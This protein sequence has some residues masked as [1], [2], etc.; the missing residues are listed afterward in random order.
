MF[1]HC[2]FCLKAIRGIKLWRS[3]KNLQVYVMVWMTCLNPYFLDCPTLIIKTL[4]PTCASLLTHLLKA[5][6]MSF[7]T[8][9]AGCL[10][11]LMIL[12]VIL[13]TG[14]LFESLPQVCSL[15]L[16]WDFPCVQI[17]LYH[18][19]IFWGAVSWVFTVTLAGW[20]EK[21]PRLRPESCSIIYRVLGPWESHL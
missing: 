7:L 16:V 3:G 2:S 14:F 1:K 21:G 20:F 11:S 6:S 12:M 5:P 4:R 9:L 15:D 13:A 17:L 8:Q 19:F 18:L 10:A